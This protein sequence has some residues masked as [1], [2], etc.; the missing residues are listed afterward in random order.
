MEVPVTSAPRAT[1]APLA[2]TS[3]SDALQELT[4]PPLASLAPPDALLA[5]QD[6]TVRA[7][8]TRISLL[9]ALLVTI[10]PLDNPSLLHL[11][12]FAPTVSTAQLGQPV[13][14]AAR[15]EP[16]PSTL[17][18]AAARHATKEAT[19]TRSLPAISALLVKYLAS[20]TT[21]ADD[22]ASLATGVL[23]VLDSLLSDHARREPTAISVMSA[24]AQDA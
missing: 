12:T 19:A 10:A 20:A 6:T 16:T 23:L 15:L 24:P 5:A 1:I 13:G 17:A 14:S 2:L 4:V 22:H 3:P 18:R 11:S 8:L 9:P 21:L 7:L